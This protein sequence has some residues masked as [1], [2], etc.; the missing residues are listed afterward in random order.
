MRRLILYLFTLAGLPVA[1]QNSEHYFDVLKN[2]DVVNAIY[3]NLDLM[4]VDTLDANEVIG[5]GIDGMLRSLDPYTTYYPESKIGD[6]EEMFTGKFA[7]IGA[8]IRFVPKLRYTVI[9]EPYEGMPAAI[10][11]LRK[12]DMVLSIDDSTMY[13]KDTKFVSNHLR[14]EAGT[15]FTLKI[16]RP[17]TGK[18]MTMK[19]TRSVIQD[20]SVP[21]YGMR[22]DKIGYISLHAFTQGC[23]QDVRKAFIALKD[24]GMKSLVLDLRNNG[25]GS[26][27]EAISIVNMFVPKGVLIVSNRGK[28]EKVT[29]DYKTT[30]EPIDTIMPIVVLVNDETASASEIT[31][32]SLQDLDR[33]VILG[34][35]TY[36]KGLVQMVVDLPYNGSLKLTTN[37]YYIPSGRC[38]QA[39]DYKHANGGSYVHVPDSLTKVFYTLHGREVR[40]GGG[41]TPDIKVEPDSLPNIA[42][43]LEYVDSNAVT[44]K[45]EIDYIAK[46]P[47]IAPASSFM[48][49]DTDYEEFKQRVLNS[50]FVYD[51][52]SEKC[53]KTL[54]KLA[55]FE[56]YYNDAKPEFDALAKKLSHN[57]ARDLDYN[58]DIIRQM[59]TT[60]I[61][62]AYY[63]Q[64]GQIENSLNYDKQMKAAVKLLDDQTEYEKLLRPTPKQVIAVSN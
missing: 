41:I 38:I 23:A 27:Q 51:R 57:V 55:Q 49:S 1:A 14:G 54:I 44:M 47:R 15:T 31:S 6:L 21:Y 59:I 61:V 40:D 24:K 48:L 53:L 22:N 4:Y 2:L 46:H 28:L 36:G 33:A 29:A 64:K 58:K 13:N 34:T 43:Y 5:N 9:N 32:G 17:T 25:G 37:K 20:P 10:A 26:E 12:G 18:V 50:G 3:R 7:G 19:I 45:Y 35:R 30:E 39:K 60:D 62:T 11:G 56:G 8:M 16:K 42:A 63:Y 52:E